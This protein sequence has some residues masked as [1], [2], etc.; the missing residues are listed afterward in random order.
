MREHWRNWELRSR[1]Q[2]IEAGV[3]VIDSI[4]RKEFES[5]TAPLRDAMRDDPKF[6]PLLRRIEAER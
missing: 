2:A 1:K 6:G 4:D 3:A 5:A